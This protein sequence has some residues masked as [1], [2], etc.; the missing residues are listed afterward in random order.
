MTNAGCQL[1]RLFICI[2]IAPHISNL[3]SAV[4]FWNP[5][6]LFWPLTL[7]GQVSGPSPKET[8]ALP[9]V[10]GRLQTTYT[11]RVCSCPRLS[12]YDALPLIAQTALL[13]CRAS[14]QTPTR[15]I[16]GL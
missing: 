16:N 8:R 7:K 12:S 15:S 4:S 5:G 13:S 9:K 1:L 14:Y 10:G 6:E 3:S 11:R 2:I